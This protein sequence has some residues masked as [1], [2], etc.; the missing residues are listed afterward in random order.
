MTN[1]IIVVGIYLAAG[2]FALSILDIITK[3]IRN[4]L[5]SASLDTQ[6]KLANTGNYTGVKTAIVITLI[7]LFLFWPAVIYSALNLPKG[8]AK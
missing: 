3:R 6:S 7:A 2:L 8:S 5:R 4:R 1:A